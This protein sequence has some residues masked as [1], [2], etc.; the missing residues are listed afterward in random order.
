MAMAQVSDYFS[1]LGLF[2]KVEIRYTVRALTHLD[3]FRLERSDLEKL[4]RHHPHS[5]AVVADRVSTMLPK[6]AGRQVKRDIYHTAGLRDFLPK[7]FFKW[8]PGR[9]VTFKIKLLA[10]MANEKR[11][12]LRAASSDTG[13]G[14]PGAGTSAHLRSRGEASGS[15]LSSL[16]SGVIESCLAN[17]TTTEDEVEATLLKLSREVKGGGGGGGW[18]GGGSAAERR[19]SMM[20]SSQVCMPLASSA[21]LD[22]RR[23]IVSAAR[24]SSRHLTQLTQLKRESRT[25]SA[26]IPETAASPGSADDDAFGA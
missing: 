24:E 10:E 16:L 14:A 19:R 12:S 3:T 15:L 22:A 6:A 9:G 2:T 25:S 7:T 4:M 17:G 26:T 8:R 23:S 18:S 21:P 20:R 1:E 11:A 5:A 13:G